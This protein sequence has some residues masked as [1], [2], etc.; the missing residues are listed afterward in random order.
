MKRIIASL[1]LTSALLA[2]CV[3]VP[4]NMGA[5]PNQLE[6]KDYTVVG[7][8]EGSSVGIMLFNFIPINQNDRFQKAYDEAVQSKGGDRLINPVIEERWFWA[9]LLNGYIFKVK[10]T[11]VKNVKPAAAN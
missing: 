10:G 11:V 8:G 2:G 3:S 1:L 9:Y 5:P 4:V 7:E 6:G